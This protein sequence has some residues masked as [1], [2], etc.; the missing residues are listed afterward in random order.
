MIT[1]R[2]ENGSSEKASTPDGSRSPRGRLSQDFDEDLTTSGKDEKDSG[3]EKEE[4]DS[5]TEIDGK[6]SRSEGTTEKR[7]SLERKG[8][9]G[10]FGRS[11]TVSA[12]RDYS[13]KEANAAANQFNFYERACQTYS[14]AIRVSS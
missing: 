2:K 4:V 7:K 5:D 14:H 11:P 12:H 8:L 3:T 9:G 1:K 10:S 13:K 6:R